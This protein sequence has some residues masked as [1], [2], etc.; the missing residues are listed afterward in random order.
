MLLSAF[1][2]ALQKLRDEHDRIFDKDFVKTVAMLRENPG[3]VNQLK[4]TTAVINE[5]LR[6][7]PIGSVI[8]SPPSGV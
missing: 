4:Y 2:H 1:P 6:M 3:L 8:R 7:F 5:T